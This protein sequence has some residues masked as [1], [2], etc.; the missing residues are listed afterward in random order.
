MTTADH[1][2]HTPHPSGDDRVR[3]VLGITAI[4]LL[5]VV[6]P[7]VIARHYGAFGIP[8]SDDWSYLVTM[9]RVVDTGHLSFN[10]WV[11][12]TLVGQLALAAPIALLARNDIG[13]LQTFTAALGAAGLI[14]VAMTFPHTSRRRRGSW[15]LAASIAAGPLWGSLAAS[16]MTDIP[17]FAGSALAMLLGV[18]AFRRRPVPLTLVVASLVA[19]FAAFTIR[20]YAIVG[21]LAAAIA[22]IGWYLGHGDRRS[23]RWLFITT[24]GLLAAAALLLAWWSQVPDGHGL[25]PMV[26]TAHES[27]VAILKLAGFVRLAGLLLLPVLVF[28]GPRRVLAR[29]WRRHRDL[30]IV[31]LAGSALWLTVTA[32]RVPNDTF[33]GNYLMPDGVLS[34]IVVIG[35]RPDVLPGPLWSI[36]TLVGTVAGMVLIAATIPW[37]VATMRRLRTR[38]FRITDPVS[39]YLTLTV[40]GY[41]TIFLLAIVTGLQAYD[42]YILPVLPA[43]G[44]L[45]LG[46]DCHPAPAGESSTR[47]I[48]DRSAA[49]RRLITTGLAFLGLAAVGLAFTI[50]SA[51]FDGARWRAAN[52]A[53][54][55]GWAPRQV[56]GGFEWLNY[57]RGDKILRGQG[58][59]VCVTVHVNPP[60]RPAEV[61]VV[62][63]STAPTRP[64]ARLVAF[65]TRAP[66]R[67]ARP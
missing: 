19:A 10:H 9:F 61:I 24:G 34:D 59:Q 45:L 6:A 44:F 53:V 30:T 35:A 47:R 23:A 5:A 1:A 56:N 63:R 52:A 33:V 39:T 21:I 46:L 64:D 17:T 12:M 58:E 42:R 29:A 57:H 15:L 25:T 40:L 51:S 54:A 26:P 67:P 2:R 49:R 11:S 32:L 60:R 13:A 43:I 7:L 41:L 37:L 20:Q 48:E 3:R 66:C 16:F 4:L 65:R 28:V 50:D 36:L 14:G 27:G 8:R 31:V 62:V 22:G 18:R 38:D 55:R